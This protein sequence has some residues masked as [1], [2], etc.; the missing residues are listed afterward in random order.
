[1]NFQSRTELRWVP[2]L[3]FLLFADDIEQIGGS[4]MPE[5]ASK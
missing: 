3:L 4:G 1:V 5:I 2:G